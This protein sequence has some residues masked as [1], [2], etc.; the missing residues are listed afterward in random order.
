MSNIKVV[1]CKPRLH[2]LADQLAGLW[3]L[4]C[5]ARRPRRRRLYAPT[6][7]NSGNVGHEIFKKVIHG[8]VCVSGASTDSRYITNWQHP[9]LC[10]KVHVT[11]SALLLLFPFRFL[12]SSCSASFPCLVLAN[13]YFRQYCLCKICSRENRIFAF[14][15]S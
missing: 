1:C 14:A 15:V 11:V 3:P 10:C 7:N 12:L 8:F 5:I 9:L 2:T 13:F 6:S 4:F